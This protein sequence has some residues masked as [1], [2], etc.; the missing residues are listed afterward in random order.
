MTVLI[1]GIVYFVVKE[2]YRIRGGNIGKVGIASIGAILGLIAVGSMFLSSAN[3]YFINSTTGLK[4]EHILDY[5]NMVISPSLIIIVA[6]AAMVD[7]RLIL[8]MLVINYI[9]YLASIDLIAGFP[10]DRTYYWSR[11]LMELISYLLIGLTVYFISEMNLIKKNGWVFIIT[12]IVLYLIISLITDL[13]FYSSISGVMSS[14]SESVVALLTYKGFYITMMSGLSFSII[15]LVERVYSNF[16]KLETFSTKDDVSYYKM[17]L[18]QNTLIEM[19]DEKRINTGLLAL[20]QIKT[21]DKEVESRVLDSLRI[22]T[23]ENYKNSFHFKA[24]AIHYG[25]FFELPDTFNLEKTL[26][27]N[28]K[29]KRDQED[30]LYQLSNELHRLQDQEDSVEIISSGAIYGIHSYSVV[31]LIEYCRF[32]MTP[33]VSRSNSSN[34]IIYDYKRVKDRLNETNNVRNLPIDSEHLNISYARAISDKEIMYPIIN[35]T[36]KIDGVSKS[37]TKILASNIS[38]DHKVLILRH[39][40]YQTLRNYSSDKKGKLLIFNSSTHIASPTFHINDYVKKIKRYKDPKEVIIGVNV[41]G[42]SP[43]LRQLKTNIKKLK[44]KGFETAVINP[45]LITQEQHDVIGPSY[46][47][48]PATDL[49]PLKIKKIK[50]NIETEAALLNGNLV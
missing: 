26:I 31:E 7:R 23:E 17:S 16:S 8:P 44:E 43:N 38:L 41:N 34:I 4:P 30:A 45:V 49:N 35:L 37:L 32:L 50:L 24:S 25:I 27:N 10:D 42:E 40:A 11:I 48:D 6:F 19:I 13:L 21:D 33:M 12:T 3:I 9:G 15:L 1:I 20:F 39:T 14:D 46:I 22:A 47:L 18:A 36:T 29:A 5:N 2:T 28:K